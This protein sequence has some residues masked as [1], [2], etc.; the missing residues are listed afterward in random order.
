LFIFHVVEADN[1]KAQFNGM[2]KVFEWSK[3][4]DLKVLDNPEVV[5]F[6]LPTLADQVESP[7][8]SIRFGSAIQAQDSFYREA[9]QLQDHPSR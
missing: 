7:F 1:Q 8:R 6:I 2:P 9:S 3:T 5:C 4:E